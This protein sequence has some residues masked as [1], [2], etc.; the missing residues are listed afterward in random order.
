VTSSEQS[1]PA[2]VTSCLQWLAPRR[3]RAQAIV[4]ALCLWGVGAADYA[5]PGIFDR[6]GNIKFQDFLQ[7]PISAR[8][9]AQ[10]RTADLYNDQVLADA[11]RA[12]VGRDTKV[13]LQYF[14][15]PQVALPFIPL[16]SLPFRAQAAI[17]VTLSLLLY[18]A[19]LYLLWKTCDALRPYAGLIALAALAFPPLFHFFVR[20]QL[21]AVVLLCFTLA[22]LAFRARREWLAGIALGFLVFKPQFLVAIPLLLLL[23]KAW[24]SVAGLAISAS[25]QI[26]LTCL[27][28]GPAVMRV[29]CNVLLHSAGQPTTTELSLSPIQMHSLSAFWELLLPWP[30]IVSA[31]YVLSSV[32]VIAIAAV[33]WRSASPLTL[34]FSALIFAAVLVNPHLYIYDLLALAPALLL[35]ADWARTNPQHPSTPTLSLLLYLAFI[36]PMLGP[37]SRWTHLQ[38]SVPAFA[39]ILYLVYRSEGR[40]ATPGHKLDSLQ[41]RVV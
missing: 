16:A 37:L 13:S 20:G 23:A 30:P 29:Y 26:A 28:F 14:Y 24:K 19:C 21:S 40:S 36:L 15:G 12:I 8:L 32:V 5:T 6:A 27:Y 18:F 11:I 35:L 33:I 39:A 34:R 31:L 22:Y 41:P 17:W 9:I 1:T 25:A 4:L 7:F 10:G 2:W 3:L 38:L